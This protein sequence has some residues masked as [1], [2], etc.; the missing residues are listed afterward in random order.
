M[1]LL[2]LSFAKSLNDSRYRRKKFF[3]FIL[4]LRTSPLPHFLLIF[5]FWTF[6][7][8]HDERGAKW[9]WNAV[10]QLF[11]SWD[12]SSCICDYLCTPNFLRQN[13]F[14][15]K[16]FLLCNARVNPLSPKNDFTTRDID[17]LRSHDVIRTKS[18][19]KLFGDVKNEIFA[20]L[21]NLI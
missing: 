7:Y 12:F 18:N 4:R 19:K 17:I 3:L 2:L 6:V 14:A 13:L 15:K 8:M 16:I 20:E 9:E 10:E 5:Y 21:K 11:E 1:K